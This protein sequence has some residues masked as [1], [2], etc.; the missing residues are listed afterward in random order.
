MTEPRFFLIDTENKQV[1]P[2]TTDQ[3]LAAFCQKKTPNDGAYF[4][5][6]KEATHGQNIGKHYTQDSS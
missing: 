3:V 4:E 1:I 6:I 5:S 2:L